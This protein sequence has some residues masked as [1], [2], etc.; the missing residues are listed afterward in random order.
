MGFGDTYVYAIFRKKGDATP[1]L[2][3]CGDVE[4]EAF[5]PAQA[6]DDDRISLDS[7]D[8]QH[9]QLFPATTEIM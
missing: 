7:Y 8:G 5:K 3:F 6:N 2:D 4:L 1:A 9:W